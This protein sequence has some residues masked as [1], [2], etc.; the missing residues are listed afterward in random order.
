MTCFDTQQGRLPLNDK[1][2]SDALENGI[3]DC[4]RCLQRSSPG[5]LLT[6]Q[7]LKRV[8]RDVKYVPAA[9]GEVVG[10]PPHSLLSNH[11]ACSLTLA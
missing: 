6:A 5:L 8:D 3:S 11:H 7:Q 1:G 4:L 10:Q 9:G 2:I